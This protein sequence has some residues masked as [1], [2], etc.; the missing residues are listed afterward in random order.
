MGEFEATT[1]GGISTGHQGRDCLERACFTRKSK[2]YKLGILIMVR[3]I[4]K[5]F[6]ANAR[7]HTQV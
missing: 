7:F 5:S 3:H 2:I 6:T 1:G 4:V